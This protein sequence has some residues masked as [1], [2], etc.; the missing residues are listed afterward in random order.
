MNSVILRTSCLAA[1]FLTAQATLATDA[2]WVNNGVITT[3]PV[4]DAVTVVNNG[5][6]TIATSAPFETS[7]TQNYT[8]RGTMQGSVGFRFRNNPSGAGVATWSSHF[9]NRLGGSISALGALTTTPI[10]LQAPNYL[11]VYATN[12][13]NKGLLSIQAGGEMI[14]NGGSVDIA[15]GGTGVNPIFARGS[16]NDFPEEGFFRPD[17]AITDSYWAQATQTFNSATLLFQLGPLLVAQSPPHLVEALT[18]FCFPFAQFTSLQ[19]INPEVSAFTNVVGFRGITLTNADGTT[20]NLLVATNIT[21]QAVFVAPDPNYNVEIRFAPSPSPTNFLRTAALRLST[22]FTNVVSGVVDSSEIYFVDTLGATDARGLL[23]NE[24]T[25][26][27]TPGCLTYRPANYLLSRLPTVQFLAGAPGNAELEDDQFF[28]DASF[29]NAVVTAAY[30][31]YGAFVDSLLSRPPAI[32]A[33][34]VTNLPGRVKIEASGPIN[35]ERARLQAAGLLTI[36]T[37]HLISSSNAVVDAENL[38]FDLGSTNGRLHIL[39]LLTETV[40]RMTGDVRA[41]SGS[42]SNAFTELYENYE[43]EEDD[44]GNITATEALVTNVVNV[45]LHALM[46]DAEGLINQVPVFVHDLQ[47]RSTNGSVTVDDR[48]QVVKDFQIHADSFTLN[49]SLT[50]S[51]VVRDWTA[52]TAPDLKNFTNNG[53][54]NIE[55]N[56]HFGDDR[57]VPYEHFVNRGF[58]AA[59]SQT[60]NS[61]LCEVT[62]TNWAL[63]GPLTLISRSARIEEGVVVAATDLTLQGDIFRL[64]ASTLFTEGRLNLVLD[65]EGTLADSGPDAGNVF[66]VE[67]GFSL[68]VKPATGD[69]LGSSF[70]SVSPLFA[71]ASHTWAGEDRG[72]TVDGFQN[73]VALG[74][75]VLEPESF[76]SDFHFQGA[77]AANGLYVDVLDL[78]FL[79]DYDQGRLLIDPNLTIYF[80]YSLGV[81]AETLD[82]AF[83]GRLVWVRDFAGPGSSVEVALADGSTIV[84]NRALRESLIIDSDGDGLA[85]GIDPFPFDPVVISGVSVTLAQPAQAHISWMGAPGM[86]YTV[87][88]SSTARPDDWHPLSS[89]TNTAPVNTLMT[90]QDPEPAGAG[91]RYYRVYYRP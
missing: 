27:T 11:H 13:I 8:N 21:R 70:T 87:E 38:S 72:A 23:N 89:V 50:L 68:P 16:Q 84:V 61:D 52:A 3:P 88:Y 60:V 1:C 37:P 7:N 59:F 73:N 4:V 18:P 69:L 30:A 66:I 83:G 81:P 78:R 65:P 29:T 15:R 64:R 10:S 71:L 75:L 12:V 19:L 51:D 26:I 40:T 74:T 56:A 86:A 80:A 14:I 43:I 85:N 57:L 39:N 36:Q 17:I 91:V 82:G 35:L 2:I 47:L 90:V 6:I 32:P 5:T 45:S 67:N 22:P 49:G 24:L 54:L 41:W 9:E 28:Y 77:G 31:G 33:G 44:E 55:N 46:V 58:M 63:G 20:T 53:F 42:W 79:T 48:A 62:G 25:A 76:L 34:T